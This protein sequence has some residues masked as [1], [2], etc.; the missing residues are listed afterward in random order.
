MVIITRFFNIKAMKARKQ[1]LDDHAGE[2]AAGVFTVLEGVGT[3][4]KDVVYTCRE[5]VRLSVGSN[6][7]YG[8]IV[9]YKHVGPVTF[10]EESPVIEFQ[11]MGRNAGTL[12][13]GCLKVAEL[14]VSDVLAYVVGE[15]S[16]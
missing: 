3:V 13:D 5:L 16:V 11:L 8:V 10:L 4:H 15:G 2:F 7:G 9:D 6:I 12:G 1:W 14:L